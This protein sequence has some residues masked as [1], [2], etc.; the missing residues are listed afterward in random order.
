[1]Q[2]LFECSYINASIFHLLFIE[3]L[4]RTEVLELL[5]DLDRM[6]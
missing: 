5:S 4:N 6:D 2:S 1:M 3:A